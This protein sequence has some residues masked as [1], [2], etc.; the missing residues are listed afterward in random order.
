M[1]NQKFDFTIDELHHY[2]NVCIWKKLRDEKG[3][4]LIGHVR[5]V[6]SPLLWARKLWLFEGLGGRGVT[7]HTYGS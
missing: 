6:W 4:L 7:I 3:D 2:L 5:K 1:W